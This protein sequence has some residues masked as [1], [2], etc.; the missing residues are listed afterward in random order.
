MTITSD[1]G[2]VPAVGVAS[3]HSAQDGQTEGERMEKGRENRAQ[4]KPQDKQAEKVPAQTLCRRH[5]QVLAAGLRMPTGIQGSRSTPPESGMFL[6][7]PF[8][9]GLG[10]LSNTLFLPRLKDWTSK[11]WLQRQSTQRIMFPVLS[12]IA[13][14]ALARLA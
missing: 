1:A 10:D 9:L 4:V 5:G 6:Q 13:Y 7:K 2:T 11:R 8:H 12:S 3:E 14:P